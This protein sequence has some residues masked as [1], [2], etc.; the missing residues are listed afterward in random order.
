MATI[1]EHLD[2][3]ARQIDFNQHPLP[4]LMFTLNWSRKEL[5]TASRILQEFEG[6]VLRGDSVD[7][8]KF[9]AEFLEHFGFNPPTINPLIKAFYRAEMHQAICKTYAQAR[10]CDDF[11]ELADKPL[12]EACQ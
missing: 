2:R 9:E 12:T 6:M 4:W 3:F 7:W 5:Y 11:Q 1:K 10:K 8:D